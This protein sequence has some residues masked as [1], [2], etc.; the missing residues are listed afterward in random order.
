MTGFWGMD[1]EATRAHAERLG[2][3]GTSLE[4]L[5]DRLAATIDAVDWT[6]PDADAFRSSW[7]SGAGARL[8]E[9]GERLRTEGE[10][11]R[12]EAVE[13]DEASADQDGGPQCGPGG[14]AGSTIPA[15]PDGARDDGYRHE[16]NPWLPNW[17]EEP[18]EAALS[19]TAQ[20]TSDA[21]GWGFDRT[22]D[23]AVGIGDALGT[24]TG[25]L[26]Q[27]RRD[28]D[29]LGSVLTDLATGERVPTI[30][31]LAA[32]SLLAAGSSGVAAYELLTGEDTPFLDDRPG[33]VL[34][35][36]AG[37]PIM[38]TE[39]ET[40]PAQSLGDLIIENDSLRMPGGTGVD[41]GQIGIQ[42][43]RPADGGDP[44]Y[45]VQIPPT[46]GAGIEEFPDAYGA[47]G[48]SRDWASNLR[49][50]AGQHP[51]AMDEVRAAMDAAG[52][53]AGADVMLVGHSQGGIVATHL[54]ADPTFNSSCGDAGSYNVTNTFSVGSPVQTVVPAQAGTEVVNVTHGPE[55]LDPHLVTRPQQVGPFTVDVPADIAYTGD[56]IAHLDLQGAQVSGG[57]LQA[58]NVHEVIVDG[59]P[60]L[61]SQGTE[62]MFDNHDSYDPDDPGYGYHPDVVAATGTDPVL[63]ALQRDLEGTYIG[64][65]VVVESST[66]VSVGRGTR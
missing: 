23:L 4:S 7:A 37:D 44:V 27:F 55:G 46:E 45:I 63:S 66:V 61:V 32:S 13:Q 10:A 21:I 39:T 8:V 11:V 42:R 52:V 25:G 57:T 16:D 40:G 17:L 64:P 54:A 24:E 33:D 28:A 5:R 43:I 49:L 41:S 59:S 47:Q 56:P 20:T 31:E 6:G 51:A 26:E 60:G 22:I 1:V 36:E 50:V 65:G 58:P 34:R 18:A 14:A 2:T 62:P 35:E 15:A 38:R 12:S 53:P 30:S 19:W 9:L 48:N 3:A 29:H